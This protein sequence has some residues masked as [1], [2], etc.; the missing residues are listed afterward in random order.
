MNDRFVA[1]AGGDYRVGSDRHY[2]EERP[3]RIISLAG[4]EIATAPVTNA[5]FARFVTATGH[6]T[7]AEQAGLSAVFVATRGP[8]AL[9]DPAAWW[10]TTKGAWWREPEGPGSTINTRQDH[11]VVHVAQ[12]DAAAY[13]AWAGARLPGEAEWEAAARAGLIDADYA[14][15]DDLL[16]GGLMM[17]NFWTG[18]FPWYHDRLPQPGTTPVGHYPADARG[19]IDMIG[20]VWEWT[21]TAAAP[22]LSPASPAPAS[23]APRCCALDASTSELVILKGGSF[24][25]AAEYCQRY[26]PAARIAV[27]ALMT[28]A[29]I[30]FRLA[31]DA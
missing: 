31:R 17:A 25:C 10:H 9:H 7:V 13:A 23:P 19:L 1:I 4:F 27:D 28:S 15:G 11:P 20:N 29:H 21:S 8:V 22:A 18:S 24:L 14:W 2:P 26:R 16:P 30:G 5:E 3:A 12:A 6:V